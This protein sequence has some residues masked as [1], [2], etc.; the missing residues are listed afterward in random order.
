MSAVPNFFLIGAPKSGTT[1]LAQYLAQHPAVYV[2]PIKEPCFFAPEVVDFDPRA[3]VQF[4]R[5][6]PS[7][8]AYLDGPMR[9]PRDRGIVLDWPDYLKLF[10]HVKGETAIGE[11]SVSYL[12]SPS[13]AWAIHARV[14]HA[15]LF[16]VLRDPAERLFSH[17]KAARASRAT[18]RPFLTWLDEQLATEAGRQVRA[19]SAWAGHYA[20]HL[21]RYFDVFPRAQVRAYLYEDFT[22]NPPAT[23]ADIFS[24]LGVDPT[25]AVDFSQWHNVTPTPR[26][27]WTGAPLLL[28]PTAAERARAIEL[29]SDD[30]RRLESLIDRDLS[31]WLK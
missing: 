27:L 28:V 18:M 24:F 12:S 5:D 20:T 14:P 7:L 11:A 31:A 16:A 25:A 10:K 9:E 29:Y 3:R 17:Y 8:R 1:S 22:A 26:Y 2:S 30:I 23:L 21:Q 15:R 13:A 6:A 19:G 4:E